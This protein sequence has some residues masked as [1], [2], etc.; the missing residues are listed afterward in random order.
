MVVDRQN[1]HS[2]NFRNLD[3]SHLYINSE[4]IK[5]PGGYLYKVPVPVCGQLFNFCV[6]IFIKYSSISIDGLEYELQEQKKNIVI[7]NELTKEVK[8][9]VKSEAGTEVEYTLVI[10]KKNEIMNLASL[11]VNNEEDTEDKK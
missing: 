7:G 3:N 2:Y 5:P 4:F 9:A 6:K 11:K 8:F 10:Y 1:S